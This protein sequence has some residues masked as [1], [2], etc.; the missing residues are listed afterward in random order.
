MWKLTFSI[1][2]TILVALGAYMSYV[3]I[4]PEY[5]SSGSVIITPDVYQQAD[6]ND[7]TSQ[8]PLTDPLAQN[9]ETDTTTDSSKTSAYHVTE[10]DC[11]EKCETFDE[12]TAGWRYCANICGILP[13]T[14]AESGCADKKDLSRDYCYRDKAISEKDT[15]ICN[16]ITDRGLEEQCMSRIAE[17][18]ID[19][20]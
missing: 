17:I 13:L 10:K 20:L 5:Q 9:S 4:W 12:N 6:Q 7:D 19:E 11:S 3:Y 8:E 18:I 2:I 16:E 14:E 1:L 15:E